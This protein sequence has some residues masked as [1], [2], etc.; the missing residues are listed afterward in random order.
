MRL[1]DDGPGPRS[2]GPQNALP[3][4][5]ALDHQRAHVRGHSPPGRERAARFI[6]PI[7]RRNGK[8]LRIDQQ[9]SAVERCPSPGDH[10]PYARYAYGCPHCTPPTS[11]CQTSPVRWPVRPRSM[12]R[13][14]APLGAFSNNSSSIRSAWRLKIAKLKPSRQSW[15]PSGEACPGETLNCDVRGVHSLP[16]TVASPSVDLCELSIC[17]TTV[18]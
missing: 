10:G 18:R 12:V 4:E 3:V 16:A 5:A 11:A 8:R 9:L 17:N 14:G 13:T 1:I 6:A 2:P 7:E 15:M